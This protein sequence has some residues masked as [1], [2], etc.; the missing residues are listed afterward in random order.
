MLNYQRVPFFQDVPRCSK[1][2]RW[3]C[4]T[5][6][7]MPPTRCWPTSAPFGAAE[8][9]WSKP[10]RCRG[11]RSKPRSIQIL[12]L[13]LGKDFLYIQIYSIY[14]YILYIY[15]CDSKIFSPHHGENQWLRKLVVSPFLH[16][17]RK[18]T[19][20]Y[21][22]W[23]QRSTCVPSLGAIWIISKSDWISC[24]PRRGK[25][26]EGW[27]RDIDSLALQ[28]IYIFI[29]YQQYI[30]NISTYCWMIYIYIY[31]LYWRIYWM[32]NH[33]KLIFWGWCWDSIAKGLPLSSHRMSRSDRRKSNCHP[34][35]L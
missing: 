21:Q 17:P 7:S 14:I 28:Y 30:N 25:D 34:L 18:A 6:P 31:W 23:M 29:I 2:P 15:M 33:M 5:S 10:W 8:F 16:S 32:M 22:G 24:A 26:G 9:G 3:W 27:W 4:T 35:Q 1:I 13:F 20:G 19:S 11:I 12:S